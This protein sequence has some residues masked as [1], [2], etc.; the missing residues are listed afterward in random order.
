[1]PPT[2]KQ[3]IVSRFSE[4]SKSEVNAKLTEFLTGLGDECRITHT[5]QH[6]AEAADLI[7]SSGWSRA[8]W[9]GANKV[10]SKE[11]SRFHDHSVFQS[12]SC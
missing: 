12:W 2:A 6:S 8:W 9:K 5:E 1:M 7:T 3:A 10:Y 4:R 11:R